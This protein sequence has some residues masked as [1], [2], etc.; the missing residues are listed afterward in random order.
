MNEYQPLGHEPIEDDAMAIIRLSDDFE[1]EMR[2]DNTVLNTYLGRA[3]FNNILIADE[4]SCMRIFTEVGQFDMLTEF[5]Q[6]NNFQMVLNQI[7]VPEL[8]QEE[9][10]EMTMSH[11]PD[12]LP[13]DWS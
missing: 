11:L 3:A 2:R 4:E 8:V 5:I 9:Y 12:W 1:M 10:V 13:E 6:D 7:E